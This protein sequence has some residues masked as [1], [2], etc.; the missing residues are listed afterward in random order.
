MFICFDFLVI[1]P[2]ID[3]IGQYRFNYVHDLQTW[4]NLLI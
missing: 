1:W 3:L 2:E 4:R